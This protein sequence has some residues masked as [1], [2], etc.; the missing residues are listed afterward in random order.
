MASRRDPMDCG[1][2]VPMYGKHDIT[3]AMVRKAAELTVC[4][5]VV[6]MGLPTLAVAEMLDM[7]GLRAALRGEDDSMLHL[8][9]VTES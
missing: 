9:Q 3:P 5:T 7:M 1:A 2:G 8:S 6:R 4:H